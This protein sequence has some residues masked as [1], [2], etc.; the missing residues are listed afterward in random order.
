MK[1]NFFFVLLALCLGVWAWP[2]Y[3]AVAEQSPAETQ[4]DKVEALRR[5]AESGDAVAM[6]ML[7]INFSIGVG[8]PKN[9][10]EAVKWYRKAAEQGHA[11]AQYFLGFAYDTGEGVLKDGAEAV[12]WYRKAAEQGNAGAQ[13]KLGIAYA[14]GKGVPKDVAEAAKW[15]LKAAEQGDAD[16]QY[17]LGLMYADGI[18]VPKDDAEA[19]KW[20]RKAAEQGDAFAQLNLGTAYNKGKGVPKDDAQAVVWFRNAAEQGHPGAQFYLGVMY[21]NGKGVPKDD[22]EAVKWYRNAAEQGDAGA[23]YNLG[24]AY[25]KGERVPK[26]DAEAVKWFRKAAEQGLAD[27][28]F[29]L[30]FAYYNGNGVPKD[31]A[32]AVKWYR[33]AA[34]QGDAHAQFSLGVM[35][36]AGEGVPTNHVLAYSWASLAAAGGHAKSKEL[37]E[38]LAKEMTREQIAEAQRIA[39]A[40]RPK[41]WEPEPPVERPA[42]RAVESTGSGFFVSTEGH[43]V[44]NHHVVADAVRIRVQTAGGI[45]PAVVVRA[46]VT[47]D[48]AI[49]KVQGE[50]KALSVCGSR[51]LKLARVS[52]LGYPNPGLQG[53]AGKYS[54]GEVAALSGPG[55]DPRFLQ[56]SVPIQPGNS[57]GPLV[58]SAGCVVGVVVSQLDKVATLRLTGNLPEN[59]NYAV[60][61]TILLGVMESVPGLIEK[62]K[63][64]TGKASRDA[65]EVAR[66]VEAAC[67]MVLVEK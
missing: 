23:Q 1:K 11:T 58:D 67:G 63:P 50:F 37:R 2:G 26:D 61:G 28:Q 53:E 56:I 54:S 21:A 10:V 34:E 20:Y 52:T 13:C 4:P 6:F 31:D 18:G 46:D 27:A 3:Q 24:Y 47:N 42:V 22:A 8:V 65:T 62:V 51:G 33:K 57:G 36:A 25:R 5:R 19:V 40:F 48:L 66:T 41:V 14:H 15:F 7:G 43:F 64:E 9:E 30:G 38:F 17:L 35:Y 49:L 60:K 29:S 16:A 45:L 32:E 55:D 44:T 59:V 39:A 12:K